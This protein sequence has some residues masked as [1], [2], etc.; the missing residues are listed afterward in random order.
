M[1]KNTIIGFLLIFGLIIG[2]SVWMTPS[3]ADL[4]KA[5]ARQDS[6]AIVQRAEKPIIPGRIRYRLLLTLNKATQR[7]H[8]PVN[9]DI[10][11]ERHQ[12]V[13]NIIRFRMNW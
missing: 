7:M 8:S 11:T 4:L 13:T 5:K 2:Y 9:T 10:L 6:L 12:G 1:N 3:K